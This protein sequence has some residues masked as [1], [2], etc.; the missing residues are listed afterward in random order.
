MK[1]Q[2]YLYIMDIN[3]LGEKLKYLI[4]TKLPKE[5]E[6]LDFEIDGSIRHSEGEKFLSEYVIHL[7]IDNNS[8]I[9]AEVRDISYSITKM[10]EILNNTITKYAVGY[11][12][13]IHRDL[14]LFNLLPARIIEI[15][16]VYAEKYKTVW[17]IGGLNE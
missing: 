3:I 7:S 15:N 2:T 12:G 5:M 11:K 16:Y 14:D 9:D 17:T 1:K 10:E 6:I 4:S 8:F 13:K